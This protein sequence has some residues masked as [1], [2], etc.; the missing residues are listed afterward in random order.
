[1]PLMRPRTPSSQVN[2]P[3]AWLAN[4]CC[5]CIVYRGPDK[6]YWERDI[7][8]SY[9]E[10]TLTIYDA[11]DK[12]GNYTKLISRTSYPGAEYVH[13]GVV[14]N[15][16][17]QEYVFIDDEFDER[18]AEVGP[19]TQ[20][21]PTTHIFDVRDLEHPYYTGNFAGRKRR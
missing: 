21:L 7:C 2:I 11:T 13:Q 16:M 5:R 6:R 3:Q 4:D 18:D 15:A 12:V 17:W 1:M 9:N 8:Y 14:N 19:M 10:D 20:G